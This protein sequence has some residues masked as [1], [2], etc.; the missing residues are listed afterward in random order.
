MSYLKIILPLFAGTVIYSLAAIFAGPKGIMPMMHLQK[1]R[2]VIRQ[3]LDYLHNTGDTL[4]IK[5]N[6]LSAD[7]D[8]ISVYAHELGFISEGEQLI[9]LA[10]FSGGIDRNYHAGT[11]L[12]SKKAEYLPEWIC[13][14]TAVLSGLLSFFAISYISRRKKDG[15]SQRKR[16]FSV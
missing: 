8:T 2:E 7:A 9:K 14:T 5:L 12:R 3:N 1:E 10:G 4:E 11:A 6:N 16:E 15:N 13:K